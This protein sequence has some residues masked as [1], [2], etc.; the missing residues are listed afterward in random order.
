MRRA[1]LSVVMGV[2]LLAAIIGVRRA[3]PGVDERYAPI[4]VSGALGEQV[5]TAA[6]QLRVD[7][8]ELGGAVR[9]TDDYGL[10]G[11]PKSTAGIWVVVWAT[12]AAASTS[13]Q[14]QGARLRTADGSEYLASSTI[15]TLD[16]TDLSP[17]IPAYGPILFEI[18]PDRLTGAVLSVTTHSV[19]GLDLL[20]PAADVD[21][22]LTASY[23]TG[24]LQRMPPTVTV[25]PVR[26]L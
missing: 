5:D 8:L 16:K 1:V 26:N 11:E 2:V 25:G 6:F 14:V 15:G 18:P 10:T 13:L 24:L 22:G 12:V 9:I 3:T 4:A 20:G 7:R 23:A 17:G 19:K 21:L